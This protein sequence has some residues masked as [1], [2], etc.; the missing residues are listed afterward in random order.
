MYI[1]GQFKQQFEYKSFMPSFINNHFDWE[2]RAINV[3]LEEAVRYLG[4]L[5]AYS[6]L[7]PDVDFFIK[8]HVAKEATLSNR[9]EGT[10]T[11]ID[12]ALLP[13]VEVSPEKKDDWQEVHNYINAM[14]F[15]IDE[16]QRLPLSIRL[17][18]DTHRILLSGVRGEFKEPGEIRRSQNWIGG[19]AIKDAFFIPPHHQDLPD[20]L[21]DL[22]KFWNNSELVIPYLIKIAIGHYQFETIHPF[23]DGNGR[24]G[25]L[26]ITLQLVSLGMLKRPTLYLSDFF[27]R[28]KGTYYDS[29]TMVRATNNIE[30][31]IKFFLTGVVETSKSG[32]ETF[33]SI[34]VLR[35]KYDYQIMTLGRKAKLANEFLLILFSDPITSI[36]DA[37]SRLEVSFNAASRLIKDFIGLGILEEI[38][39]LSRNR[40]FVL[41]D[42]MRLFR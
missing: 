25:R 33:E 10:R 12:D 1:S 4:E 42:Y 9:I 21:T 11:N 27:E 35:K 17:T 2:D 6:T 40:L 31:W 3:L 22:E 34:I 24:I 28:N 20:L 5:N 32:K 26:L 37:S 13:E 8:M 18:K 38:T 29:L 36:N 41:N 14:S 23:L 15:A 30:Q 7:V 16:L 39:G 19:A